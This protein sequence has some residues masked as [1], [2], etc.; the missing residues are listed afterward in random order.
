MGLKAGCEFCEIIDVEETAQI[1]MRSAQV[2]AFFPLEP[3]T[4]GHTMLIPT[5]H[6]PDIWEL[7]DAQASALAVETLRVAHAVK[8]AM[9]PEGLNVIQSN[10]KAA[11]Q[12]ISH[13]HV[14]VLPRWFGDD[15]GP[16]WPAETH[17]SSLQ[18]NQALLAIRMQWSKA[19]V[20]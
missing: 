4:L 13:V 17:W 19:R 16:I 2:V 10:G 1:V 12:T 7:D 11:T 14:H 15:I 20:Q 6:V 8:S 5:T 18:K 9:S 3:A